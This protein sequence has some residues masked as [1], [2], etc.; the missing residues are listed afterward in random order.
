MLKIDFTLG[1]HK[2]WSPGPRGDK[3]LYLVPN[4]LPPLRGNFISCHLLVSII[5][6]RLAYFRKNLCIPAVRFTM[7]EGVHLGFTSTPIKG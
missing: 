3:I 7:L 6:T 4:I 2:S 5:L 1:V